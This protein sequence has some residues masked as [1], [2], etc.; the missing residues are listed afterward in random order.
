[1]NDTLTQALA[2][3]HLQPGQSQFVQVNG[4][5]VEIHRPAD[6]ESV[7]ADMVM[8]EPWVELASPRQG[9]SVPVRRGTL[10]LPDAPEIPSNW[11]ESNP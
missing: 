9:T 2:E 7:F 8:L 5:A 6:E 1:M 3:L 4:Y 10:P 11:E